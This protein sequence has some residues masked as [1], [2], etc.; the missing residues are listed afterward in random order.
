ML[1]SVCGNR[2]NHFAMH[3]RDCSF[4]VLS[5]WPEIFYHAPCTGAACRDRETVANSRRAPRRQIEA[6]NAAK[7]AEQVVEGPGVNLTGDM[8]ARKHSMLNAPQEEL[9]RR[10]IVIKDSQCFVRRREKL[11]LWSIGNSGGRNL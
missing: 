4:P 11:P 5:F 7:T 1:L 6:N 8:L 3:R 2:L 9:E 10:K